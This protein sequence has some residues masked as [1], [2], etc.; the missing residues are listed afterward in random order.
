M[1]VVLA[2]MLIAGP[3]Q[4]QRLDA[5][6]IAVGSAPVA[7]MTTAP[8]RDTWRPDSVPDTGYVSAIGVS[9]LVGAVLAAGITWYAVRRSP[10]TDYCVVDDT[11]APF[12]AA[13]P[14]FLLGAG[15]GWLIEQGRGDRPSH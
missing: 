10:C 9:A 11:A 4:A 6:R 12:L 3:V 2:T 1:S 8:M 14:G 15:V 13:L 7:A 5:A